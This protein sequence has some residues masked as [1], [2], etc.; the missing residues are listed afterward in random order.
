MSP[1]I[2]NKI[3]NMMK[4]VAQSG[5]AKELAILEKG[6]GVKTG[7][8]QA[9]INVENADKTIGKKIITH[10]WV[11]GFYAKENHKYTI[12]VIIEGTKDY[13]KSAIPLFKE[14]C[15]SILK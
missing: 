10:G 5:T 1:Y 15:E 11:T 4:S 13:S 3:K 9:A 7:T 2:V 12:T 6:C 14:I 8:T